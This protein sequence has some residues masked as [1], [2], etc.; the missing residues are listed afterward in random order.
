[1]IRVEDPRINIPFGSLQ[2][3]PLYWKHVLDDLIQRL[4]LLSCRRLIESHQSPV[5]LA[6][7]EVS[8]QVAGYPELRA[9]EL[10]AGVMSLVDFVGVIELAVVFGLPVLVVSCGMSIEIAHAEV[11]TTACFDGGGIDRPIRRWRE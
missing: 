6:L 3:L 1:M 10:R 8:A 9:R 2:G 5:H 4:P 11:G 7:R